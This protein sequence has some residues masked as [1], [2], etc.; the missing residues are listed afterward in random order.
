MS[1]SRTQP[2]G[3]PMP[4]FYLLPLLLLALLTCSFADEGSHLSAYAAVGTGGGAYTTPRARFALEPAWQHGRWMVGGFLYTI[5]TGKI[6]TEDGITA[7]ARAEIG[8]KFHHVLLGGG[9]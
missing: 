2:P 6:D 4:R 8:R 7:G 5:P 9:V 3:I 1:A